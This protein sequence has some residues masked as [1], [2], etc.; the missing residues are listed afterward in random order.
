MIKKWGLYLVLALLITLSLLLPACS[1]VRTTVIPSSIQSP[2]PALATSEFNLTILHT[3]ENHGHWDPEEVSKVSQGGI[4]RRATLVRQLRSEIPN[5]LLVDSGDISQGTLYFA[6]KRGAEGRD[7]YNLLGYDAVVPGNHEL[8]PGPKVLADNFLNG[9]LFSVVLANMDFSAEP[10]LTGKIPPYVIKTIGGE[11]I[12]IFGLITEEAAITSN[13][14]PNIKVKDTAQAARDTIVKLTGQGVNKIILLSHLGFPA[15]LDIAAKVEG[16]DVIVSGHTDTLMGDSSALDPSL[17]KPASPYPCVVKSPSGHQTVI[18][19]AY[20]W[21]RLLGCLNLVFDAEGEIT[22]W[23]GN[24]IFVDKNIADDPAVAQQLAALAAAL[25]ELMI[26]IIGRTNVELDGRKATVRNQESNLGNLV[27]DA[28][29]WS[30]QSDRTRIAL[31]NGGGLRASIPVGEISYGKVLECLPFGNCLVQFDLTGA[32]VLAAL[33]NGLSTIE[34]D[35]EKSGGRFLQVAGIKFSA[36]LKQ[37]AGSRVTEVMVGAPL[38][39]YQPLDITAAYRI[40]TL[41]FMY[42]G[43]DGYTMFKNG[44]NLRGGDVPEDLVVI[45]YL[46]AHSPVS[47]RLEDR[48]TLIKP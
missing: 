12:G 37:P 6:L 29:L 34:I 31:A 10:S 18:V 24:P 4:A 47:S 14:G 2:S 3:S 46:K 40:V 19:H 33:E 36:D 17:G 38:S 48:I 15:D 44:R 8:D 22:G 45:D 9:A 25:K 26:T 41:D 23:N 1:A 30:T 21:G 35:P 11:K 42:N 7:F 16:I 39:G 32:E 27:A 28:M 43:G 13:I 5:T 20:I